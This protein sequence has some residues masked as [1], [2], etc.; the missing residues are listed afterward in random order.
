MAARDL[1]P[2][3]AT[4]GIAGGSVY[5][6]LVAATAVEHALTLVSRDRRAW[7][8]YRAVGADIERLV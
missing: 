7:E 4:L 8:A 5:D 1:Q 3:L 2:Q 6:A